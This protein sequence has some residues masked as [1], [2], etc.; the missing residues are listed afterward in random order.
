[1]YQRTSIKNYQMKEDMCKFK[2]DEIATQSRSLEQ[3]LS[4]TKVSLHC[5]LKQFLLRK[6]EVYKSLIFNF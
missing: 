1:M 3:S 4:L 2:I 5:I 6:T